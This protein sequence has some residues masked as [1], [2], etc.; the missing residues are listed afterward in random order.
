MARYIV[1]TNSYL[2]TAT[3]RGVAPFDYS[4]FRRVEVDTLEEVIAAIKRLNFEITGVPADEVGYFMDRMDFCVFDTLAQESGT[5][6]SA[7]PENIV[8][9]SEREQDIDAGLEPEC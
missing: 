9:R 4:R 2:T 6:D 5:V 7:W 1:Q 3:A 8:L